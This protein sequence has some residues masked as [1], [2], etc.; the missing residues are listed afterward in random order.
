MECCATK[1]VSFLS[2]VASHDCVRWQPVKPSTTGEHFAH[3]GQRRN[4][5][6]RCAN[7][8]LGGDDRANRSAAWAVVAHDKLLNWHARSPRDLG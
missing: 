5:D 6:V 1:V 8:D 4:P 7:A 2:C 3:H